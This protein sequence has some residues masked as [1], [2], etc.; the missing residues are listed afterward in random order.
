MIRPKIYVAH[1]YG[2]RHG[3]SDEECEKNTWA[4]VCVGR[5]LIKMG[6]NPFI[7]NL[8]HFVHLNW[9]ESPEEKIY[10][11]IVSSWIGDCKAFLVARMPP[12]E[13]TGVRRELN[14]AKELCLDIYYYLGDVPN[15]SEIQNK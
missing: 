5:E 2:R 3:L 10:F 8:Y 1:T 9:N 7:P 13:D 15:Y 14:I 12:W 11:D 6:W 4:S